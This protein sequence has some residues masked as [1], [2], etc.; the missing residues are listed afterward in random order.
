MEPV[1]EFIFTTEIEEKLKTKS[2]LAIAAAS[3][4]PII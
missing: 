4:R 2:L 3:A 1:G